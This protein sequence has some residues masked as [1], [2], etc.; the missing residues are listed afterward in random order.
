MEQ[1]A[2][3]VNRFTDIFKTLKANQYKVAN[4]SA[5][6]RI[7]KLKTLKNAL[8]V[9]Y[10]QAIREALQKDLNKPYLETDLTEIYPVIKEI[11]Y[12]SKHLKSWMK[13]QPVDTPLALLGA[14][15]WIK[16]E[17]KG[18][19]LIMAPWNFPVNLLLVPLV[20]AIA[21]GNTVVLK[22]SEMTA[23]ASQVLKQI[24]ETV[25]S[26]DEI[27]LV[28]GGIEESQDLLKLPF[29]H[30]FF[31]GSP[32]VGKIVMRAASEHLTSVTL[33]LG[34]K[35]PSI[36]H[37]S[38]NLKDVIKKTVFG[39]F[40]NSGQTC[41]A[42]DYMLVHESIKEE[43]V[44]VFKET[45]AKFYSENPE[46]SHSYCRVINGKHHQRL[47]HHL[48]DAKQRGAKIEIGGQENAK[49]N[50]LAPTLVL[51]VPLEATLMQD[52]IFGP[53]LPVLTFKTLNDILEIVNS[54]DKPLALY[55]FS[56]NRAFIKQV[57]NTTR[58]GG[59]CIN[60]NLIHFLNNNLPFGGSNHSGLGKSHGKFGFE[61]F[62]NPRAVMK[63]HTMGA[64]DLLYPPYTN[65]KQKLIDLTLKWF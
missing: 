6:Q 40:L 64:L 25:F 17:P 8:E 1:K 56:K 19:C 20:S 57:I 45:V 26:S 47:L 4:T 44:S 37:E 65:L 15:S 39:K 55:I 2:T 62:S 12:A 29:N 31:T 60:H 18:V 61:A 53:I 14:S 41:I 54:K 46:T 21:S 24:I 3:E 27:V 33:E 42:P 38:A 7:A 51:D 16:Y 34:G 49:E 63:Q 13:N 32:A 59:T 23:H 36:I 43:F 48:E 11:K 28:E 52:E 5:K 10:K 58:A 9:D 50:Y 30:I 22:P 35:S